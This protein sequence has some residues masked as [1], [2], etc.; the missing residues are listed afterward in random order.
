MSKKQSRKSY[1]LE[2]KKKAVMM[3]TKEGITI[4]D[5]ADEL[6]ISPQYLSKWRSDLLA[7]GEIEEAEK[8]LDAMEENRKLREE[9]KQL[10]MENEILKKAA[11][12][13]ASQ[14]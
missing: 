12:Y 7:E 10:R 13:F 6:G 5:V 9:L 4:N 14:K 8:R 11:S 3:T 2:F 1:P